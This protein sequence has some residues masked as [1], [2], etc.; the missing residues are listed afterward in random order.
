M[1]NQWF[2]WTY[3]QSFHERLLW[4]HGRTEHSC[5]RRLLP[6][7]NVGFHSLVPESWWQ[8]W[9]VAGAQELVGSFLNISRNT[10]TSFRRS[11]L[12]W[13]ENGLRFAKETKWKLYPWCF[14]RNKMKW[15]PGLAGRTYCPV[16]INWSSINKTC[17]VG[18]EEDGWWSHRINIDR[19]Y[20]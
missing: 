4:A 19:C 6:I 10:W 5:T 18:W 20:Y 12:P 3:L 14:H 8:W 7:I 9:Q 11:L 15:W 2:Y 16:A 1:E 17:G 13:K